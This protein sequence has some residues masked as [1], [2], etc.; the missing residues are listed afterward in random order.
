MIPSVD[1]VLPLFPLLFFVFFSP[2]FFRLPTVSLFP[3]F[4]GEG[5][6]RDARDEHSA[7]FTRRKKIAVVG[8]SS[9]Q[10]PLS[11]PRN[12][13]QSFRRFRSRATL[14]QSKLHIKTDNIHN[15]KLYTAQQN[16][17]EMQISENNLKHYDEEKKKKSCSQR[18]P[19]PNNE[20]KSHHN[21]STQK[22]KS[23]K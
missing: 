9:L 23:I 14:Y 21:N 19:P 6:A 15:S 2:P 1:K 5:S 10:R 22:K 3:L 4:P 17:N 18:R 8:R 11:P 7:R 12:S 16:L 20:L 13:S